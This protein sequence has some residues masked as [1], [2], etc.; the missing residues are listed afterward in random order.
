MVMRVCAHCRC[1]WS[2]ARLGSDFGIGVARWRVGASVRRMLGDRW[3][4]EA[5]TVGVEA[6]LDMELRWMG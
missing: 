5:G 3:L 4:S 1:R 6:R 2:M